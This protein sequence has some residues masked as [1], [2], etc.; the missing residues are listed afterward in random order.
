MK[1]L[2]WNIKGSGSPI[3]KK[4]IKKV[5]CKIEPDLVVL[6][7]VKREVIDR[8]FVASIWRSR[9]K[10]WVVLPA[11]GRS[12]GILVM[13][14]V[15]TVTIKEALV[16]E[17]SVSVLVGDETRGDW[18]FSGIY[19]PTKRRIRKEFWDELSGLKEICNDRWCVGGDFNV[20]R[21][22][23]EKFN[24][25]TNT[26][27]MK[28]FDYLIGELELMDPKLLNA[29]FTW[30]NFRQLPICCRLDRFL[31]TNDWAAGYPCF[32]Q[33]MEAR[34]VSDHAP[35]VLDTSP[36]KWGPTPFRFEN[37]W[38]DHK[39]FS[40]DFERWWKEVSVEGW[41]GYKW[42]V[43]LQQIKPRLKS[44]NKDVFG[45]LRL[46]EA[47]LLSRLKELDREEC[48]GSWSE[49]LR[50]ERVNLKRDLNGVLAKKEIMVRQKLKI[51]WAKQGDA[52]SSLFH[53]L[54]N[55]RKSKNFIS[56]IELDNGEFVAREEDIVR[57]IISYF[58]GLYSNQVSQFRGFV[59]VEWKGITNTLSDWL[60]RPFSEEEVKEAVFEC[61]GSKTPGPD[62]FS[63]AVFQTQWD[64]VKTDMMKVFEEFYGSGIINGISNE[65]YICLI[66]K[67]LNSCRVRD[68]RPISL[69]TSLYK[70]IAK[71]LA[72][73]LQSVLPKTISKYQGAFVAGRQIL[74]VVLVANEAVEDYRRGNREGLVFKID[75]EKA[76][77]N[78]S[79]DFLDFVLQNKNFG[80][81][82]RGWIRGCL[83][84]VSFS[85][86]INGRPRGKFKGFKGLRQGD[87]LSPFLFTLV[88]DG[89]SRLMEKATE[90]GFVKGWQVGRDN[91]LL[92]HLQFADDT[93]FFLE[94]EGSSFKNLLTVVGLFCTVSG[95]KIN[96]AKSTLLGMGVD[97]GTVISLADLVGCEVGGWPTIYLG[98]PLGGNP[99]RR[100]FWEPVIN[101]VSKRL[102][103]WKRAFLSKGGRLTLIESVLSAIPT[104]FLSLFRVPSGVTKELEKIMRNFFWK[105]ADGDGGD[106]LV[107]WKEVGRAKSK[108][109]LGIG[110]LKEKNKALLFK[111]F[112]RFPL[113]Q[114]EI[115]SK[116]IKS[117][118]GLHNNRWDA[119]LARRSSYRSP[120][121]FISSLH[122]DF[123]QLVG[124][125][126][127]DGRR[128]RFWEDVWWGGETLSNQ[129]G[130][131]YRLSL[132]H[133][134]TIAEMVVLS[135][136]SSPHGW[137]L[138]FFRNL[139]D[140]EIG[141][142]TN[143]TL[144]LD[145][146]H[147]IEG[148][149]DTRIWQPDNSGGFSSRSAFWVLRRDDEIQ[150]FRYYKIIWK[151]T[152]PSR[153]KVFAW[154]LSLKR[155]N[156]YDVLQRKR[157][158]HCLSPNW[159]VMCRQDQETIS[160]LFLHCGFA[161]SLWSKVFREFDLDIDT[162]GNLSDLLI[163]CSNLR[164][165]KRAKALWD[166][167][168]W[169]VLWGIWKERNSRTFNDEKISPFNL[170]DN[171]LVW[172][173]TW[174]KS[175][176]E[177]RLIS[178]S[179]LSMGWSFIL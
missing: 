7:E 34:V 29:Q 27:S 51:Q 169:A 44:W 121:K 6:Q 92:S 116:V 148:V 68:F 73:R 118:Y 36:P 163:G 145:Q 45:D 49:E 111:W 176:Q 158:Y 101:K 76:Y 3:K 154:S 4:A 42:M 122:E 96:M 30:S 66:P 81:K 102:D 113:E 119:G 88:A 78:V 140:R 24:S 20:V 33:E 75:F 120:W 91:V 150:D 135:N 157:S 41:E 32:R 15:R 159:C 10:E 47:A 28:E 153:I 67:K 175:H 106:H 132:A 165:N 18:W 162:P 171:I 87:P 164:W 138:Q 174:I 137:D 104:Y 142:L 61:D 74:D 160:H 177:F 115:W 155:I 70:I 125:R 1:I 172:V 43:R 53:R 128:I 161:R 167:V 35:V 143:L 89:L 14:D 57:E 11:L 82:W 17:F 38:L 123:Q 146:V 105:G 107:S 64:T 129:F 86:M 179:D 62:G 147:L 93:L 114:D 99:C 84:S 149:A 37:A 2:S 151:S 59:G 170:W 98:M 40:S 26:R 109:G 124:F 63:L 112:W 39:Q 60:E 136:N 103:G 13:W 117:K 139:H 80:S 50:Q 56:K 71:V 52:N 178:F 133:N 8:A 22:V 130:D 65:T 31:F 144:I 9:F 131:L 94:H 25:T 79:W 55:T 58:K 83:S 77:D 110:R 108:G 156:T 19:G 48:S 72:K 134:R 23:S 166:C 12:G 100:T 69:V 21:R 90:S 141:H 97:E 126:V 16:G 46:I 85:V 173:A 54:L 168:L 5:I 152:I 127:G 95:L